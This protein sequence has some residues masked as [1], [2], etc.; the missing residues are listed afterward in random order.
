VRQGLPRVPPLPPVRAVAVGEGRGGGGG[1]GG[2]A[3]RRA[4]EA[5]GV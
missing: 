3:Q 4:A 5:C 1:H 2:G